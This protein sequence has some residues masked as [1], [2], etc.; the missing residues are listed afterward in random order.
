MT[1]TP[2]LALDPAGPAGAFPHRPFGIRHALAAHPLLQLDAL[3]G[4]AASLPGDRI[5]YN[6][7]DLAPD[8]RPEDV[9]GVALEPA[10]VVRRIETA[11]AWLV[12]KRVEEHPAYRALL[13]SA[14][15]DAARQLGH[16]S[17]AA[18]GFRDVAGFV[19][20][21]S[22]RAVTPF[23]ADFEENFFVQVRGDKAFHIFD[24]GD[25]GLVPDAELEISPAK[26]RNLPYRPEFE[27]RAQVFEMGPG[28]GLFVPHAWPHWVRTGDRF[29]ISM[30]ITWKSPRVARLNKLLAAN[31]M[32]RGLG[33]PQRR[34]GERPAL[35]AAKVAAFTVARA[36]V[37]PLRRS[38]AARRVLRR[39]VFG[40]G[41]NYYYRRRKA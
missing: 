15:L 35:D 29:S 30:A 4:L 5:E 17:L 39:A 18:A 26:H 16:R 23:H 25:R 20:V 21:S 32:L 27:A 36:A 11:N 6:A 12:L 7:G 8:Q 1:D 34:P 28:D 22:A 14:L 38:E 10:E 24:N 41:A 37:E 13:E 3:A 40:A 19:F 2:L 31:G 33:L 9:R